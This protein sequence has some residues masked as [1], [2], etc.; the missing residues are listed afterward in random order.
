MRLRILL[1]KEE[2]DK[3]A[4]IAVRQRRPVDLQAEVLLR[5]ALGLS[6][7]LPTKSA[8]ERE[9]AQMREGESVA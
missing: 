8:P 7:D 9:A 1:T 2:S 3:L 5:H 6:P 4:E